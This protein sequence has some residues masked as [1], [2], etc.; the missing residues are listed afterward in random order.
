[1]EREDGRNRDRWQV[2]GCEAGLGGSWERKLDLSKDLSGNGPLVALAEMNGGSQAL[3]ERPFAA[4][5]RQ[6]VALMLRMTASRPMLRSVV[7]SGVRQA[8]G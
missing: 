8:Y 4:M 6:Q 1:M 5:A 2:L 3:D 7:L